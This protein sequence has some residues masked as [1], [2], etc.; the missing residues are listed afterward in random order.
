MSF[1]ITFRGEVKY[2]FE[3]SGKLE[4]SYEFFS[5]HDYIFLGKE[6]E[7]LNYDL[8]R[9]QGKIYNNNQ[10]ILLTWMIIFSKTTTIRT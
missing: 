5:L 6:N 7:K 10:I 1:L 4:Y 2:K 3:V 9:L 8:N